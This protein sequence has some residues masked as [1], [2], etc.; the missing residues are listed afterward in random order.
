MNETEKGDECQ[1]SWISETEKQDILLRISDWLSSVHPYK[2]SAA[3][4]CETPEGACGYFR[5][6]AQ[7]KKFDL[8]LRFG[9]TWACEKSKS[10]VIARIGFEK[11]RAGHGTELLKVLTRVAHDYGYKY[12]A[13][14]SVNVSS[15]AFAGKLGFEPHSQEKCF[16]ILAEVLSANLDKRHAN[17][18]AR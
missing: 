1:H 10:I 9:R 14:E 7:R 12:L 11:Q 2:K 13:I 15:S 4:I 16:V 6:M 3:S 8:Y 17:F 5:V 18:S